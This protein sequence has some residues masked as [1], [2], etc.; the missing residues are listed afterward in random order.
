MSEFLSML[1][2]CLRNN[3]SFIKQVDMYHYTTTFMLGANKYNTH[4]IMCTAHY[5]YHDPRD[6]WP[7]DEA[8]STNIISGWSHVATLFPINTTPMPTVP[9]ITVEDLEY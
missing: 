3:R 1:A 6:G 2:E 8:G 4:V 5:V 7:C 9:T